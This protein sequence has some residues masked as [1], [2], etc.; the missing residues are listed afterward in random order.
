[1]AISISATEYSDKMQHPNR[2]FYDDAIKNGR[3]EKG[4]KSGS[5]YSAQGANAITFKFNDARQKTVAVRCFLRGA[6]L[7]QNN[8]IGERY[9]AISQFIASTGD[10]MFAA[11]QF[12][13]QGVA[14]EGNALPI[15]VMEWVNGVSLTR[16][17]KQ[18]ID[19]FRVMVALAGSFRALASRLKGLG[20]AH[21]DLQHGNLLV[22]ASGSLRLVDY[23]GMFVPVLKGKAAIEKGEANYQSPKRTPHEFHERLDHFSAITIYLSL[24]ALA[25]APRLLP[26]DAKRNIDVLLIRESD[27][28]DPQHS[29]LFACLWELGLRTPI[30]R[31]AALCATPN[32]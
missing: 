14:H 28:K 22:D 11:F 1:M 3:A 2:Y 25:S 20:C 27:L 8:D 24:I 19:D 4:K 29:A 13:A 31:F 23:D 12:Q 16:Y 6:Y 5:L 15:V 10:P 32:T 18:H 21:G 9:A 17:V 26:L 30:E 7:T